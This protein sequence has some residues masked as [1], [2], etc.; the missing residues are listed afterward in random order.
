MN[1]TGV[2]FTTGSLL[3]TLCMPN[4][5]LAWG[6]EGH[7]AVGAIADAAL[8]GTV[9]GQRVAALLRPGE[10]LQ[11]VS[12]WADCAKSARVDGGQITYR[13]DDTRFPECRVFNA[14]AAEFVRFVA[15]NWTQCGPPLGREYCHHQYHYADVAVQRSRYIALAEGGT[16]NHDVVQAIGACIAR[17]Q[18]RPVP[19]PFVLADKREALMLLVHYVG[20]ISQPLHVGA[21]YLDQSGALLD[22]DEGALDGGTETAGGNLLRDR[23]SAFHPAKDVPPPYAMHS[24]WDAVTPALSVGGA[25]WPKLLGKAANVRETDGELVTWPSQWATDS[26]E[27]ARSAFQGLTYEWNKDAKNWYVIG[28]DAPYKRRAEE[29]QAAQVAK[30]GARLAQLLTRVLGH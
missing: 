4:V 27:Q 28:I 18:D 16:S 7:M 8:S 29:I 1:K 21:V 10:S 25:D 12:V 3:A 6:P 5:A 15:A 24:Q 14:N 13:P 23:G 17:L 2:L 11:L 20:D 19:P 30:A 26:L 22:P 9:A